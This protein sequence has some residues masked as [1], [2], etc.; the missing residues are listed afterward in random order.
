MT[1][2]LIKR[3][4]LCISVLQ[5]WKEKGKKPKKVYLKKSCAWLGYP[6]NSISMPSAADTGVKSNSQPCSG[7]CSQFSSL[8]CARRW[9]TVI[10]KNHTSPILQHVWAPVFPLPRSFIIGK[11]MLLLLFVSAGAL[12]AMALQ[13]LWS[14]WEGLRGAVPSFGSSWGS[15]LG[16]DVQG[17]NSET[18]SANVLMQWWERDLKRKIRETQKFP[19]MLQPS[20]ILRHKSTMACKVKRYNKAEYHTLELWHVIIALNVARFSCWTTWC[21]GT[22]WNVWSCKL[23]HWTC[24]IFHYFQR[25]AVLK[26]Q[27]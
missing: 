26:S 27:P 25:R 3:C 1:P 15:V 14:L 22:S 5:C 20:H 6:S 9:V 12:H 4:G 24:W 17:G 11:P 21:T 23:I 19:L 10:F 16:Q 18:F 2:N 13:H 8:W 7:T